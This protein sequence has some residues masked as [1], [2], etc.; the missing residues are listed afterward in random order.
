MCDLMYYLLRTCYLLPATP[1]LRLYLLL[2]LSTTLSY[3]LLLPAKARLKQPSTALCV[4]ILEKPPHDARA[5]ASRRCDLMPHA[6]A[7]EHRE[8]ATLRKQIL[9]G[10]L[11]SSATLEHAKRPAVARL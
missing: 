8:R 10:V 5:L 11:V 1:E 3:L 2:V 7:V 4:F 6:L 9:R